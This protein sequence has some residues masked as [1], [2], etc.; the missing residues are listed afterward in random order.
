MIARPGWN[1]N[2][3]SAQACYLLPLGEDADAIPV[4]RTG[5]ASADERRKD[6]GPSSFQPAPDPEIVEGEA[7]AG[8]DRPRT[9]GDHQLMVA[10]LAESIEWSLQ[11]MPAMSDPCPVSPAPHQPATNTS[12]R[13]SRARGGS[14]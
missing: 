5:I 12:L 6:R 4:L 11:Q 7:P 2:G 9:E 13:Q 1:E 10:S 8:G 3:R 14:G